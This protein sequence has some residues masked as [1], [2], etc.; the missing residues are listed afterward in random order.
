[1]PRKLDKKIADLK[2]RGRLLLSEA[3][4]ASAAADYS[5]YR[6]DPVAYVREVLRAGL[7]PQQQAILRSLLSPPYK[8]LVP[9]GHKVGKSFVA[10]CAVNWWYDTFRPATILTTA[11]TARQVERILWREI[12]ILRKHD[13][14]AFIGPS[15]ARMQDGPEHFAEGFTAR[16]S[17]GFQGHHAANMLI[18]FDEAEG[19]G[20]DFWEAVEPMLGG[21]R[22]AFLAIYNPT[23]S[24]SQ[25]AQE[26]Q[27]GGYN[28]LRQSCLDH[29]NI[30][31]ELAGKP[32]PFPRSIR[33]GRLR[34]M[35]TKWSTIV[36]PGDRMPGDIDLGG[37]IYR[38]GPVAQARLLGIRPSIAFNTVWSE[39]V[40]SLACAAIIPP[41]G[42]LQIGCDVARYGDDDT[43]IHVREGGNSLHHEAANGWSVVTTAERCKQLATHWGDSRGINPRSV[44]IAVDDSGVGGGVTDILA[45]DGWTVV[46][47]NNATAAPDPNEY[48]NLRSALWFDLA[49]AAARGDISF[50][51]LEAHILADL[52]REFTSPTY[53]LD[54][55]GRRV[56]EA[57]DRTKQR[58]GRSPDNADAVML[59][60]ANVQNPG[61]RLAGRVG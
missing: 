21:D 59:A 60:Y 40:F 22:Y 36:A 38:P 14:G 32:P 17:V 9:S 61:H 26:E 35:L 41:G 28:L 29:P 54:I 5:G 8:T 24:S 49:T 45:A 23:T 16:D 7:T 42:C 50:A 27:A 10:A 11:Y 53:S 20:P 33:L 4:A 18:V 39:Y 30:A 19:V 56:V 43:A 47:L 52:R 48:P 58:L 44:I 31:A 46:G 12:R 25:A 34:E 2:R 51:Q 13:Q 57:K 55:R 37:V 15:A 3:S 6:D 1:M